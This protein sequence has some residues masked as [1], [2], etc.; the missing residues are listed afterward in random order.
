MF[1][2]DCKE[3]KISIRQF[4][5]AYSV[6]KDSSHIKQYYLYIDFRTLPSK[7]LHL[8]LIARQTKVWFSRNGANLNFQD[9][10]CR[11]TAN[12]PK[13]NFFSLL[14]CLSHNG[15]ELS[16]RTWLW[17][18][19]WTWAFSALL[20]CKRCYPLDEVT[21][22]QLVLTSLGRSISSPSLQT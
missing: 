2:T 10:S 8:S 11:I 6:T 18:C 12:T 19:C 4:I 21:P 16:D 20:L 1:L 7:I 9:L 3:E 15:V 13:T 14:N 17:Y 5:S 22:R